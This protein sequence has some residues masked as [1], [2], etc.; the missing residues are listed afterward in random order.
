MGIWVVSSLGPLF[1]YRARV[2]WSFGDHTHGFLLGAEWLG[3]GAGIG[4]LFPVFPSVIT[5]TLLP[6]VCGGEFQLLH[7]L[8]N[9]DCLFFI[10]APLLDTATGCLKTFFFLFNAF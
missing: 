9:T 6:S 10:V 4:D 7:T 5:I 3:Q 8:P 1:T 2:F